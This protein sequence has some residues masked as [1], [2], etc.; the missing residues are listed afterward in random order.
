[1]SN[2]VINPRQ[3]FKDDGNT[4]LALGTLEFFVNGQEVT[5]LPIFSD[6]ALTVAQSNPYTLDDFGVVRADIHYSGQATI[7]V[8]NAAGQR[9]RR[10]DD[11]VASSDG[12]TGSIT[13][14]EPSVAAMVADNDLIVGDVVRT[15]AY[16]ANT[17]IAGARYVIVAGATG[18]TDNFL[19]HS[20]GNGLQ[21]KLLD[22]EQRCNFLYGGA[23][24]DGGTDDETSMQSVINA[25]TEVK[26]PKGFTFVAAN[27][28]IPHNIRFVGG[29]EIKQLGSASGDLFQI[30]SI[31]VTSVKFKGVAFD[32]NQQN[33]NAANSTI[34]WVLSA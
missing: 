24:G 17:N 19:F 22:R 33:G 1:M 21:A 13:I 18:I 32:G 16:Y 28:T 23:R 3:Q 34:G 15:A 29:G 25:C 10:L 4:A 12:D 8:T 20:L 26:V 14:Y 11:V 5:Q 6:S 2:E 9:I 27:L 31:V 30:T 7:V